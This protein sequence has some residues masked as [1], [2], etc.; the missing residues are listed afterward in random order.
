MQVWGKEPT[1]PG[2][3]R[4]ESTRGVC[5]LPIC[6]AVALVLL[7]P[8]SNIVASMSSAWP[9]CGNACTQ[10]SPFCTAFV[11]AALRDTLGQRS[12][13]GSHGLPTLGKSCGQFRKTSSTQLSVIYRNAAAPPASRSVA[14]VSAADPRKLS[15]SQGVSLCTGSEVPCP[16]VRY[17]FITCGCCRWIIHAFSVSMMYHEHT[18]YAKIYS[19]V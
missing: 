15:Y 8:A 1:Y 12:P 5:G 17:R 6:S 10:M 14:A 18:F 3:S 16:P 2:T 13:V 9:L 7:T 11:T 4:C 19:W